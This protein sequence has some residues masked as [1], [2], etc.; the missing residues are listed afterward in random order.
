[1]KHLNETTNVRILS[2]FDMDTGY[3]AVVQKGM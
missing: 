2:Q 3:Q 1:M